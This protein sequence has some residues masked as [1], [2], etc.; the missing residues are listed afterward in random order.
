MITLMCLEHSILHLSWKRRWNESRR[1]KIAGMCSNLCPLLSSHFFMSYFL[2]RHRA[3]I[4]NFWILLP[5]WL[6]LPTPSASA[7]R[8]KCLLISGQSAVLHN[9][10]YASFTASVTVTMTEMLSTRTSI[11]V[12][13]K[14]SKKQQQNFFLV[15]FST[16]AHAL[17]YQ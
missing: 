16:C 5:W 14:K 6:C 7:V 4:N 10:H 15:N 2:A 9:L 12:H 8:L 11:M 17:W 1:W 13:N 3:S